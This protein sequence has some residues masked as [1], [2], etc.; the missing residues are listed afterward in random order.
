MK[1]VHYTSIDKPLTKIEYRKQNL[2]IDIKPTGF[3]V[4]DDDEY[5]WRNWCHNE[6]FRPENLELAYEITLVENHHVRI[7]KT[8]EEI[9]QWTRYYSRLNLHRFS[10][11]WLAMRQ[12][13]DGLIITP[14]H[15]EI[16][17]DPDHAWYYG[18]DCA[19]G[20]IWNPAAIRSFDTCQNKVTV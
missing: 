14:Y 9:K 11:D 5:G 12:E 4:S 20:C 3:W 1:L 2:I 15:W 19:S 7:I 13:W 16:R 10:L 18:W 6:C 8:S 17:L